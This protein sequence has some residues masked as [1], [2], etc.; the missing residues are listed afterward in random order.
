MGNFLLMGYKSNLRSSLIMINYEPKF[1]TIDNV[2]ESQIPVMFPTGTII[3]RIFSTD[4]RDTVKSMY[5][6]AISFPYTGGHYPIWINDKYTITYK[7][8]FCSLE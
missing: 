1:E 2:V 3:D 8:L 6:N 5:K 7:I 4:P